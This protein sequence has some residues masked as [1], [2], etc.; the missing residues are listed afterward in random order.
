MQRL[1]SASTLEEIFAMPKLDLG[2]L[3]QQG[4][5]RIKC[6]LLFREPR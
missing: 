3:P 2:Q 5:M 4:S 1:I 6:H